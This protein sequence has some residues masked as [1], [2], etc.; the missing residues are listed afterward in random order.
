MTA[1]YLYRYCKPFIASNC[2]PT[3]SS[4]SST[5]SDD[6]EAVSQK[7]DQKVQIVLNETIRV[8]ENAG[9]TPQSESH[10]ERLDRFRLE[11]SGLSPAKS[12][13]EPN[14]N[15]KNGSQV[16]ISTHPKDSDVKIE[17]TASIKLIGTTPNKAHKTITGV[18]AAASINDPSGYPEQRDQAWP[19]KRRKR[20]Q[21]NSNK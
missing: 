14:F 5:T 16:P 20:L 6:I 15:S 21:I 10:D 17:D 11:R 7:R 2:E 9:Y 4:Q 13:L 12:I 19:S 3:S 18:L 8:L 1:M